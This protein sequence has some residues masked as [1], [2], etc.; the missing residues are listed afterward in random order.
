[1]TRINIYLDDVRTPT[2][3]DW[4]VVR[5]Y[6]EFVST[7]MY[8]GLE[9]I[10]IISLD[11][12]LGDS[13][14]TEYYTNVANNYK[15]DYNNIQEKTGYDCCKYLVNKSIETGI[16]LPQIYV[17]S[18]NP[19]GAHNMMGYINNYFKNCRS[20]QVCIYNSIPHKIE[21]DIQL[22]PEAR[23]ARWDKSKEN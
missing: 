22:S 3:G 11:H 9:N 18:A 16:P 10:E 21:E 19:I 23:K 20:R 15:L 5:N 12:D 8:H 17:H 6:E 4:T 14:M 7:V 2:V 13:A 1:M